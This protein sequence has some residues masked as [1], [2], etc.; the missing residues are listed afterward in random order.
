MRLST[1][2]LSQTKQWLSD[3]QRC[4]ISHIIQSSFAKVAPQEYLAKYFDN[5]GP[6]QRKLRLYYHQEKLVGYC[7]ITFSDEN[8]ITVIRA[9][10]AFLA[11]YRQGGNTFVFSLIQ[12]VKAWLKRPW[13][14]HYYADTMLSPAMYRA[15]A[16]KTAIIWPHYDN[17][18]PKGLF[19]RFNFAGKVS[20]ANALRCLIGVSRTTNYS[21]QDLVLLKASKKQEIQYYCRVNPDFD[22]GTALFVIIPI[23]FV[24][25]A[26]TLIKTLRV[27]VR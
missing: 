24:Q 18:A 20:S 8:N 22:K 1:L 6:Y 21:E 10:A 4:E 25:V 5:A 14:K 9:S 11:Q 23:S 16:K 27:G 7:L 17:P 26:K 2:D 13:R 19:E 3:A 12:S 15:I